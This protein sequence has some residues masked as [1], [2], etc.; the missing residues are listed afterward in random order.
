[1]E[2]GVLEDEARWQ[3]ELEGAGDEDNEEE[4]PMRG[5]SWILCMHAMHV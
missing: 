1:V 5:Y 3:E 2:L 4:L